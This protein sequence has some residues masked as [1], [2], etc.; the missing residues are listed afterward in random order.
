MISPPA[1]NPGA[2]RNGSFESSLLKW[3]AVWSVSAMFYATGN[4]GFLNI[5]G[6]R[7]AAQAV[8]L[9][10]LLLGFIGSFRGRRNSC[11]DPVFWLATVIFLR[12]AVPPIVWADVV[13]GIILV[14]VVQIGL[15]SD[16]STTQRI[17]GGVV[18]L[19]CLFSAMALIQSVV[20]FVRPHLID[21]TSRPY[22]SDTGAQTISLSSPWQY[23]GFNTADEATF[24]LGRQFTRLHS[25]VSE[26]SA[27]ISTF[28]VPGF[29]GL[30][31]PGRIRAFAIIVL[32]FAL[33]PVQGGT[34]WLSAVLGAGLYFAFW[35]GAHVPRWL[36]RRTLGLV[37]V[38]ATLAVIV[39]LQR[40]DVEELTARVVTGMGNLNE[41]STAFGSKTMSGRI[42]LAGMQEAYDWVLRHPWGGDDGPAAAGMGIVYALG[43]L[44]GYFGLAVCIWMFIV[45]LQQFADTFRQHRCRWTRIAVCGCGGA[46]L[47][48][49][50]FSGYGWITPAGL[51]ML[52][53]MRRWFRPDGL[54]RTED[55]R[56]RP[57]WKR[58]G[59][60]RNVRQTAPSRAPRE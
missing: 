47:Q 20:Y 52:A 49:F 30:T 12:S 57:W 17:I 1:S 9:L 42:R 50:F 5:F 48:A 46:L 25:F 16:R 21:L 39:I 15:A 34:V 56:G 22:Q 32:L 58:F 54:A 33:G 53:L 11:L 26:P 18:S 31:V 45:L 7:R 29:L 2:R 13:N 6:I 4:F 28:L 19:A 43:Y 35:A 44:A 8:L 14:L 37:A 55:R 59:H 3:C 38:A 23:L 27:I 41:V 60:R 24:V 51:L 36:S 10:P 40:F